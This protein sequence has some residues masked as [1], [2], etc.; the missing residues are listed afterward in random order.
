MAAGRH[1]GATA[2][3]TKFVA[4]IVVMVVVALV[5][6]Y[7]SVFWC[8]ELDAADNAREPWV[9]VALLPVMLFGLVVFAAALLIQIV[10]W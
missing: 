2:G 4:L 6:A 3:T 10:G 7:A 1:A 8:R 9:G 5:L